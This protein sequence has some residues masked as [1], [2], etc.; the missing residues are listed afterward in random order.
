MEVDSR[1]GRSHHSLHCHC[2]EEERRKEVVVERESRKSRVGEM[3]DRSTVDR[4]ERRRTFAAVV[5]AETDLGID[6][7]KVRGKQGSRTGWAA[8]SGEVEGRERASLIVSVRSN[9]GERE[10]AHRMARTRSAL[11]LLGRLR[12]RRRLRPARRLHKVL[13]R[14]LTILRRRS[15]A[16]IVLTRGRRE[17]GEL[18]HA[19]RHTRRHSAVVGH[20]RVARYRHAR[21]ARMGVDGPRPFRRRRFGLRLRSSTSLL[22]VALLIVRRPP[23]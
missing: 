2:W 8:L 14:R 19:I 12:R 22:T 7:R 13:H 5:A 21:I 15:V 10:M 6:R 23:S 11:L 20:V 16:A 18:R 9:T 1:E 4:E 17:G 3:V